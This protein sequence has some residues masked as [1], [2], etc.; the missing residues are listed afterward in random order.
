M[1]CQVTQ[2][3]DLARILVQCITNRHL[4]Q[5]SSKWDE[6]G[7]HTNGWIDVWTF[8]AVL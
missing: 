5:V 4:H 6:K 2:K 8:G 7:E 3:S 1:E